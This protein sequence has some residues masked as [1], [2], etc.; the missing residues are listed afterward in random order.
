MASGLRWWRES[1]RQGQAAAVLGSSFT[2]SNGEL[3][4]CGS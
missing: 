3:K 2:S 1:K 4:A